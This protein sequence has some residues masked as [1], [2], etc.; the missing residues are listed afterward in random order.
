MKIGHKS[1][2]RSRGKKEEGKTRKWCPSKQ[3][4]VVQPPVDLSVG[5]GHHG[6]GGARGPAAVLSPRK[7]AE[8]RG[9]K[10]KMNGPFLCVSRER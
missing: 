7:K 6:G 1:S 5:H 10:T 2:E 4:V 9:K 8:E 3:V